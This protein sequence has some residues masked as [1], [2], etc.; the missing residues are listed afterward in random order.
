MNILPIIIAI[1]VGA[2]VYAIG[3]MLVSRF[4]PE[5]STKYT[6][7]HIK[8]LASSNVG[9]SEESETDI[10]L[11]NTAKPETVI[12]KIFYSLPFTKMAYPMIAKA[13]LT[14]S[15]GKF[16]GNCM[17]VMVATIAFIQYKHLSHSPLNTIGIAVIVTYVYGFMSLRKTIAKRAK[18]FMNQFPDAIDIIV[19]SVKSGFPVN[20]SISMVADT[21]PSPI[22]E[23]FKQVSDEVSLGSTLVDAIERMSQRTDT[24][25]VRFFTVVLALQQEVG[26]N[27]AEILSNLSGIIRKRKMMKLKILALTSEGRTSGWILGAL[28]I[29][30]AMGINYMSPEFLDPLFNTGQGHTILG[31]AIGCVATGVVVIRRM[32]AMEI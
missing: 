27:L 21:M 23:E 16:F 1:L 31:L 24:D 8:N 11:S 5:D 25:D 9:Y 22:K 12:D 20:S 2:T 29:V 19:R 32:T 14:K 4:A 26:G 10:L 15:V 18:M 30:V 3:I 6:K 7:K 17:F 28:P 13:G